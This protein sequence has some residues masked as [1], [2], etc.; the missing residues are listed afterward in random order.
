MPSSGRYNDLITIQTVDRTQTSAGTSEIWSKLRT[1]TG[2][3]E[4]VT[5]RFS[6]NQNQQEAEGEAVWVIR[7]RNNLGIDR[8][9]GRF[10]F[11]V[12]KAGIVSAYYPIGFPILKA[13][14]WRV[15]C[16]EQED[17]PV[18]TLTSGGGNW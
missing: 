17:I 12:K 7:S 16:A 14:E 8:S 10:R 1:V 3:C 6:P 15:D 2:S 5:Q 13:N 18:E 9:V 11:L 4:Y